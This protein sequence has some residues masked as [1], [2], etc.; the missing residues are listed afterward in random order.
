MSVITT[1]DVGFR[2][3]GLL[4]DAGRAL[5]LA[6]AG[7]QM[8]AS[9]LGKSALLL[10]DGDRAMLRAVSGVRLTSVGRSDIEG[11]GGRGGV[12]AGAPRAAATAPTST[13]TRTRS[14]SSSRSPQYLRGMLLSLGSYSPGQ[15]MRPVVLRARPDNQHPIGESFHAAPCGRRVDTWTVGAYAR[16]A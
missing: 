14:P 1:G 2:L 9:S 3:P 15:V 7:H 6:G 13:A 10:S 4:G 8:T 5:L 16:V 12:V 11:A